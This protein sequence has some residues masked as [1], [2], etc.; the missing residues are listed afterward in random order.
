MR[1]GLVGM[2]ISPGPWVVQG[3]TQ[4]LQLLKGQCSCY[5]TPVFCH[6]L[7]HVVDWL[8]LSSIGS[9]T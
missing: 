2:N 4:T 7:W 8:R 6:W 3:G 5:S 1:I 9:G